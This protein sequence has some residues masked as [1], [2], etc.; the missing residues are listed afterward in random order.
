MANAIDNAAARVQDIV[1]QMSSITIKSAPDYPI[2]AADA[3]PFVASFAGSGEFYA[4]NAT[5]LKNFPVLNVEFHLS[6]VNIK[7]MQQQINAI[8]YE[9]PRRIA[10]DPTLNGTV[11]TVVM[12]DE[13]RITYTVTPFEW[14]GVTTQRVL[15]QLPIKLKLSDMTPLTST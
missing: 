9:F 11:E 5:M 3:C 15:F 4:G 13:S 6:R 14:A 2:E 12:T 7:Q 8:V 1:L 10:G